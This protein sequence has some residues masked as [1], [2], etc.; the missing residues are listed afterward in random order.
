MSYVVGLCLSLGLLS[1]SGTSGLGILNPSTSA[2]IQSGLQCKID[3]NHCF[4]E[5]W[6]K[7]RR[8]TPTGP[9]DLNVT[10]EVRKDEVGD[11][12]PI[13]VVQWKANDDGSIRDL[14]GTGLRVVELASNY[15][16]CL[17]YIFQDKFQKMRDS[18]DELW[19][20]SAE[21]VTITPGEEYL[22]KVYNLPRPNPNHSDNYV[23]KRL[24]APGCSDAAM[25][26]TSACLETGSKWQPNT[27]AVKSNDS[28]GHILLSVTFLAAE[29]SREYKVHLRCEKAKDDLTLMKPNESSQ[30]LTAVFN[31]TKFPPTCC[32]I[33]TQIQP[34]FP[35]CGSDCV[36]VEKNFN[37]CAEGPAIKPNTDA[38]REYTIIAV[39]LG[40][41]VAMAICFVFI[42][43]RS[44]KNL[45]GSPP[46][47][48]PPPVPIRPTPRTVLVV[49]SQDH[50]LYREVV[51][52]LC[53]FLQAKCGTEVVL[54]LL[55]SAWLG[56]VG[57]LPWLEQQRR[58]IDKVLV[59]CSR[60]VRAKWDAMCGQQPVKL[61]EDVCSPIDDMTT[62][63]FNLILPDLQ[64]AASLGKYVVAYFED[65]SSESDVPSVFNIGLKYRLM[66]HFEEL[67]FR[68]QDMEKYQIG[69]VNT[70]EGIS[71]DDYF[72]CP[73]GV[74]L[75]KAIEVFHNYQQ[76]NPDWF[77]RECVMDDI[78]ANSESQPLIDIGQVPQI[79]QCEP[80]IKIGPSLMV[81]E[82]S[83]SPSM[84]SSQHIQ[85]LTPEINQNTS[86]IS[87]Q[88]LAPGDSPMAIPVYQSYPN[89]QQFGV[90]GGSASC[91][92]LLHQEPE[93]NTELVLHES[94]IQHDAVECKEIGTAFRKPSLQVL[95]KL[96]DLQ[97]QL[98]PL[99][100]PVPVELQAHQQP[101]H[102]LQPP[103]PSLPPSMPMF[104]PGEAPQLVEKVEDHQNCREQQTLEE[105]IKEEICEQ[106]AEASVQGNKVLVV[107]TEDCLSCGSKRHSQ[108]S[109]QGY[110]SRDS[111]AIEVPSTA[112]TTT[113]NQSQSGSLSLVALAALQ[114]SLFIASPRT[115]G[116]RSSPSSSEL[117]DLENHLCSQ[118]SDYVFGD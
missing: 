66:K 90:M 116:F 82:V 16:L 81:H 96:V 68:L 112:A 101:A 89:V 26:T 73:S 27:T 77:E 42:F 102:H 114:Q 64:R 56:T 52:K 49:Y 88:D 13:L 41:G 40:L 75:K 22:V 25:Q 35:L 31:L 99:E 85:M 61:R 79:L 106:S 36:R 76:E 50:H 62:A 28:N 63:A 54:D 103:P 6:L 67:F 117:N 30:L 11:V 57:R 91:Q 10:V 18:N 34:Y 46:V 20:F 17:N 104:L 38:K 2:C 80:D 84:H 14:N 47:P 21:E 44:R 115:S 83:I 105:G 70:I 7:D 92:L 8:Y 58:R 93:S 33:V 37:I 72:N 3:R 43:A 65:I 98:T 24:H 32:D 110:S 118:S 78:E 53:A 111:A 86:G 97:Q 94:C 87:K 51:L 29:L 5:G 71:M 95:Q 69:R 55:D 109:D 15:Q 108:G 45:Q 48:L 60:G 19:S 100:V 59:L 39:A 1:L 9:R 4:D 74:A 23:E 113:T 107:G 12:H